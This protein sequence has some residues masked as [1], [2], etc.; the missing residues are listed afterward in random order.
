MFLLFKTNTFW[1]QFFAT[2][3]FVEKNLQNFI[4]NSIL[5]WNL[6]LILLKFYFSGRLQFTIHGKRVPFQIAW[7][8]YEAEI[9]QRDSTNWY[10]CDE[11]STW[12]QRNLLHAKNS[13][14]SPKLL[15]GRHNSTGSTHQI[16]FEIFS[17]PKLRKRWCSKHHV[18][19]CFYEKAVNI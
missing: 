15:D 17:R 1:P 11:A 16:S 6:D 19:N 7:R 2:K 4:V 10:T 18:S 12:T 3:I 13:I 9:P 5:S 14:S 8:I